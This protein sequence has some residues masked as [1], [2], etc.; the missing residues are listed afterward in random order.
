MTDRFR[1]VPGF[2]F[3]GRDQAPIGKTRLVADTVKRFDYGEVMTS[4]DQDLGAAE[5]LKTTADD[6]YF[7]LSTTPG[8]D[9]S[10]FAVNL[11]RPPGLK[12]GDD[13]QPLLPIQKVSK[14]R[15]H[16]AER[17]TAFLNREIELLA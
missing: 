7:Q 8:I 6:D 3:R 9:L 17:D 4:F 14:S 16:A 1:A 2:A 11:V 13:R 15:H 10:P 12:I 5:P